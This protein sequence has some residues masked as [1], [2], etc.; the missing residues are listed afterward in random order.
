MPAELVGVLTPDNYNY[1]MGL[2]GIASAFVVLIIWS[3][4]L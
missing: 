1:L 3:R 4:G 2:S